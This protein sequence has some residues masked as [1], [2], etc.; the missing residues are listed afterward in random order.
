MALS[1]LTETVF[2]APHGMDE[3]QTRIWLRGKLV[4]SGTSGTY[5]TGGLLPNWASNT[6]SPLQDSSGQNVLL[7]IY[8]QAPSAPIADVSVA[9]NVVTIYT[10]NTPTALQFVTFNGLT[11]LPALNGLTLQVQS[12]SA[13]VSFTVDFT[14]SNLSETAET[15]NA[16]TVIGPDDMEIES[17]SGSGFIYSY[18]K[19]NATVQILVTG[20]ASGDALNE[21]AAG[22]TPA[23]VVSDIIHFV[24]SWAKQ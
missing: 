2:G 11:T 19:A 18:N 20:T 7:A 3:T 21:L 10:A 16:V 13:G 8:S 14:T 24:A 6:L 5:A 23:G 4:F 9:S 22:T 15:G 17:V 12:V 1:L